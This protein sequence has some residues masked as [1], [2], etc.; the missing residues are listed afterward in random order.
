MKQQKQPLLQFC[1]SEIRI[2][3]ILLWVWDCEELLK[4]NDNQFNHLLMLLRHFLHLQ[5][6]GQVLHE[7]FDHV[8]LQEA[9]LV[10]SEYFKHLV[11]ILALWIIPGDHL[12]I[13]AGHD[14][15]AGAR[16]L[17]QLHNQPACEKRQLSIF[18]VEYQEGNEVTLQE[19][20]RAKRLLDPRIKVALV[21]DASVEVVQTRLAVLILD[22][23]VIAVDFLDSTDALDVEE[24]VILAPIFL[25]LDFF[26]AKLNVFWLVVLAVVEVVLF[27]KVLYLLITL[28]YDLKV[29]VV[30]GAA[31]QLFLLL[32]KLHLLEG[33]QSCQIH[34]FKD[35]LLFRKK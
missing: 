28:M 18:L 8:R 14:V 23:D 17:R 21:L 11:T 1:V 9:V 25:P 16:V 34:F 32:L 7:H 4:Y 31:H 2:L 27:L 29:I 19:F 22:K 15:L 12:L 10:L 3:L 35:L 24:D 13:I 30:I 6:V 20:P 26:P 5:E 33:R